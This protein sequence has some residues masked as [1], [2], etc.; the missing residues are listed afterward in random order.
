[1][2]INICISTVKHYAK[3][4]IPVLYTSL[5]RAGIAPNEILV[6]E[7]GHDKRRLILPPPSG[8]SITIQTNHN[9]FDFT[10]L[11]EIVEHNIQSDYWFLL[12]D[13]CRVGPNFKKLLYKKI[14]NNPDKVA[15][16]YHPSMNI[17][18]YRYDYLL[19]HKKRL[20]Q[21]KYT[22][23][24]PDNIKQ[25]K[26]RAAAEEDLFLWKVKESP[27]KDVYCKKPRIN[28]PVD[29]GWYPSTTQRIQEY[30]PQLD[31]YKLKANWGQNS[32]GKG[33]VTV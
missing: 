14:K 31:L 22:N 8:G 16:T 12:H 28:Q 32:K 2:R 21:S 11:I 30:F 13:T 23:V 4:T 10:S 5:L 6:V 1:M 33:V 3:K 9:S 24:T 27:C 17:G 19:S 26:D 7:G 18:L 20:L 25:Y 29:D 15:L